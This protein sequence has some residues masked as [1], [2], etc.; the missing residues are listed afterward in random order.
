LQPNHPESDRLLWMAWS[1]KQW[2]RDGRKMP[3]LIL[4]ARGTVGDRVMG[5]DLG[6]D[7]YLPKPFDVDELE[8][9]FRALG[10][11]ELEAGRAASGAAGPGNQVVG[12]PP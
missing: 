12:S 8:T 10:R 4:T 5:L 3:V 11:P 7:D 6:A 1:L 2:R 9:R